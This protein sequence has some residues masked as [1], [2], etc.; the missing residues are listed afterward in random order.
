MQFTRQLAREGPLPVLNF[1]IGCNGA[2]LRELSSITDLDDYVITDPHKAANIFA[3]GEMCWCLQTYI[4][5]ARREVVP[6]IC[7]N[8]LDEDAINIIHSDRLLELR[9]RSSTFLVCVRAD[10][11]SRRWAHYHLVQNRTQV[12]THATFI[13]HWVQ[14]GLQ[15]RDP[16]R[17]GVHRVAFAGQ[18]SGNLAADIE[19]WK[20]LLEPHG[21]EFVS[22]PADLWH[23][24][25]DIDILIAIRSFDSRP[26]NSKPPSKLVNAW[27]ARVPMVGGYDSAFRQVGCPGE[28]YLAVKNQQEALEAVL[29]LRSDPDLYATIVQKG[30]K[31][32]AL[33][34]KTSISE[35]WEKALTEDVMLRYVA[36]KRSRQYEALVFNANLMIGQAYHYEKQ[37]VKKL[38]RF[39]AKAGSAT[40]SVLSR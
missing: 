2:E 32:S 38:I 40:R 18:P 5:L 15:K 9:G 30:I 14:P 26:H 33:Y 29:R 13:P 16:R 6:V 22:L 34:T 3:S 23:D 20:G 25:R 35:A 8:A 27:H 36:W 37:L 7:S 1:V 39:G 28:D 11:P 4:N 21:I 12:T 31:K 10:Y 24:L 19:T 17:M